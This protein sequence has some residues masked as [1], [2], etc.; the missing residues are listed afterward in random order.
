LG[1]LAILVVAYILARAAK[2]AI[3]KIVDRVPALKK[4]YEAEPGRRSAA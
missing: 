4:H 3:A 1:A 2:W